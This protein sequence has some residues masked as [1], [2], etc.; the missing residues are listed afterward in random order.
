M[1]SNNPK[2]KPKTQNQHESKNLFEF[3][4]IISGKEKDKQDIYETLII[5]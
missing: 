3:K 1:V 4:S 2:N 5:K